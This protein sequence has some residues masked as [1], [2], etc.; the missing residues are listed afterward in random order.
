MKVILLTLAVAI[1]PVTTLA[2]PSASAFT[3]SV[4]AGLCGDDR[5]D[6]ELACLMFLQ[7]ALQAHAVLTHMGA[8]KLFC[9][10]ANQY[11]SNDQYRLVFLD[12][13]RNDDFGRRASEDRAIFVLFGALNRRFPCR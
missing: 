10:P 1:L 9:P 2:Q 4:L 5:K 3:G 12:M 11:I 8:E 13:V 6:A 7:G